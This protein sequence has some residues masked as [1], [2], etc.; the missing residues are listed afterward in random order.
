MAGVNGTY[1]RTYKFNDLSFNAS[2]TPNSPLG[3]PW[4]VAVAPAKSGTLTVRTNGTDGSLTMAGGHGITNGQRLDIY[5]STGSCYGATVGTVA[6]NVVPFTGAA[7]DALPSAATV[8]TAMVPTSEPVT[9]TGNNAVAVGVDC[10]AGGRVVFASSG[11][12]TIY[13]VPERSTTN[14]SSVW[15][16]TD[17]G[18]NPLAGGAVAKVFLSH[19]STTLTPTMTGAVQFS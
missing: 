17:G 15:I 19:G 18:T 8:V 2:T 3:T 12:A 7:G 10:P 9:L 11:N 14:T 5:W 16:S 6:G 4:S 1:N 13:A